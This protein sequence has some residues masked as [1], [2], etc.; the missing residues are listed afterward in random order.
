M[1]KAKILIIDDDSNMRRALNVRLKAEGYETIFA[2]DGFSATTTALKEVPDLVLLDLG[3]PA[4]DGFVVMERFQGNSKLCGIPI[5]V[6]TAREVQGNKD[7]AIASG[8]YAFFQKPP[9][10][11]RLMST[12]GRVLEG[13]HL[14]GG[15]TRT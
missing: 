11:E 12:I 3:L 15:V 7:R 1:S 4:G 14:G 8:A 13:T 2:A 10:N 9:D 5:I 6:L